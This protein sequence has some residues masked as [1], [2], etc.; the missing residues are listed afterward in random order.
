VNALSGDTYLFA[1]VDGK[2]GVYMLKELYELHNQGHKI[3]VPTLLN[4]RG[5]KGWIEVE[6][7]VNFGTQPLKQITLSTSRLFVKISEDAIIP[8]YSHLLF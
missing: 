8:A 4:E 7:V 6:D 5:D 2:Y 3:K 1:E